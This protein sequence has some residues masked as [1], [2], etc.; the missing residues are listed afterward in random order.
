VGRASGIR[1]GWAWLLPTA[2]DGAMAVTAVVVR[3]LGRS[4]AYR[5][6]VV[7]VNAAISVACNALR[8]YAGAA[9]C[10]RRSWR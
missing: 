6:M 1:D 5:W 2:I 7:L 4:T 9:R 8:A 10:Y 3:R